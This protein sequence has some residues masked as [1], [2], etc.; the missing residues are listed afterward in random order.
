MLLCRLKQQLM[1]E[2]EEEEEKLRWRVEAELKLAKEEWQASEA[3]RGAGSQGGFTKAQ[4]KLS[5]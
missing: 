4:V 1:S 3:H 5:S 2:Q